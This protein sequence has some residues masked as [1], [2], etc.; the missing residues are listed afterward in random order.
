M[1]K[2]KK[3]LKKIK[4]V[5]ITLAD[6]WN[7]IKK[8]YELYILAFIFLLCYIFFFHKLGSY[9]LLDVQETR[10]AT[11][12]REILIRSDWITMHFNSTAFYEKPPL[13]FWLISL[14]YM[15]FGKISELSAR[16]PVAI[17][18]TLTV[19]VTYNFAKKAISKLFAV[20]SSI[21]ML[22]SLGFFL[23]SRVAMIDIVFSFFVMSAIY[24]ALLNIYRDDDEIYDEV[25][26]ALTWWLT[27]ILCALAVLTKG[28]LGFLVPALTICLSYFLSGR[29]SDLIK[30]I[31]LVPGVIIFLIFSCAW[32]INVIN[33]HGFDFIYGY[34]FTRHFTGFFDPEALLLLVPSFLAGFFPWIVFFVA[35]AVSSAAGIYSF[36]RNSQGIL[37]EKLDEFIC[38]DERIKKILVPLLCYL[39][40]CFALLIF[41]SQKFPGA[42]MIMIPPLSLIT[43]YFWHEFILHDRFYKPM[44]FAVWIFCLLCSG[45]GI[46]AIFITPMLSLESQA[47]IFSFKNFLIGWFIALPLI[48]LL[49]FYL[50]RK[51]MLFFSYVIFMGGVLFVCV[52]YLFN[53]AYHYG[54]NE[55]ARYSIL[56]RSY[57]DSQ[58]VSFN[59]GV[60]PSIVYYFENKVLFVLDD[61]YQKLKKYFRKYKTVFVIVRTDQLEDIS[62]NI[63]FYLLQR[64][65]YYSLISNISY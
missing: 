24:T 17:V 20:L 16:F 61:D 40:S 18:A 62:S 31:N 22:S 48:S 42:T 59:M 41:S 58:L 49:L 11:M 26:P 60:N 6:V 10:Y 5:K 43:A 46:L 55:L 14:S 1:E 52:N 65:E 32:H 12:A 57:N 53:V 45:S 23:F 21:I 7:F 36:L 33:I 27:Y 39:V 35:Y 64:G 2:I 15:F 50:E 30:L 13:F 8:F 3:I 44:T 37:V 47:A 38:S 34:L 28:F 54:E 25:K 4:S 63:R 51:L 19:F 56:A 29:F 9:P